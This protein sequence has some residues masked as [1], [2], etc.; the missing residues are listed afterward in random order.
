MNRIWVEPRAHSSLLQDEVRFLF[1]TKMKEGNMVRLPA[2]EAASRFVQD[3]FPKCNVAFLAG[4]ASRGEEKE[5]SDLDIVV[6]DETQKH[7]YRKSLIELGWRIEAFI[8][9]RESYKE[10][11][12]SD[13]KRGR[14]TMPH[15]VFSGIILKDDGTAQALKQEAQKLLDEGPEKL[16]LEDI[17][18]SRYFLTDLLDDFIDADN[19]DEALITFNTLSIQIAEFILRV[20][21]NWIGR[22]KGLVRALKQYDEQLYKRFMVSLDAF[23]KAGDKQPFIQF[24]DDILEPYG[25]RL[26]EGFSIGKSG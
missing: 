16:S 18:M 26:F 8:H 6:I 19:M 2:I 7:P 4:S 20:N 10:F 14:P 21:G 15:M 12:E 23:Y 3:F 1:F 9:N 24:F 11:F 17:R 5:S 22:G 25:G 13:R